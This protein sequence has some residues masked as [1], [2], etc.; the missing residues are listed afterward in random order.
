MDIT[1]KRRILRYNGKSLD[2]Q[3]DEIISEYPLT[4]VLNGK[5]F[6]TIVCTPADLQDMVIGFLASEGVIL[7]PE[8]ILS[9]TLNEKKGYAYVETSSRQPANLEFHNKRFIGSCCGKSR[10]SFY[11]FNDVKTA[12][13][14]LSNN[15]I[16]INQCFDLMGKLQQSSSHY[17]NTGGVHNAALCS[18]DSIIIART[19]IGRHNTLDKIY[20]YWMQNRMPLQDKVIAF[21]GRISS[22]ILLKVAKIGVG[23]IISKSAPTTLALEMADELG[24]TVAGFIRGRKINVYTHPK[25][26]V[27][28]VC[29]SS[30][31]MLDS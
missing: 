21:S 12:K 11:F 19:D 17:Q 15:Q 6:A 4:I 28:A 30:E 7:F 18:K 26:I 14:V 27:D 22:E 9:V 31:E 23:I 3:E 1:K 10:Q 16:T 5:E 2:V 8:D 29:S 25:R 24:I 13:T 20:G